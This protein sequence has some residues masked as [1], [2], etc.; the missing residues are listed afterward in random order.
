MSMA[1]ADTI[2]QEIVDR[3]DSR[4]RKIS[5]KDMVMDEVSSPQET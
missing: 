1:H 3:D 2:E 5:Y 4:R